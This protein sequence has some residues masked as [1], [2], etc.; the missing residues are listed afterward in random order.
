VSCSAGGGSGST[1][2]TPAPGSDVPASCAPGRR[3]RRRSTST[4]RAGN[5]WCRPTA[6]EKASAA[7]VT[8]AGAKSQFERQP[9]RARPP[10]TPPSPIRPSAPRRLGNNRADLGCRNPTHT[11]G[12]TLQTGEI[13]NPATRVVPW[14][15]AVADPDGD[16]HTRGA[17]R[18]PLAGRRTLEGVRLQYPMRGRDEGPDE[19]TPQSRATTAPVSGDSTM[20]GRRW[21]SS[22]KGRSPAVAAGSV[23]AAPA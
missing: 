10:R 5:A 9:T 15:G 18:S 19:R 22:A 1:G 3:D 16:R 7:P 17:L 11:G 21:P 23:T 6:T 14:Q 12:L 4:G 2:P 13:P 20:T 8:P